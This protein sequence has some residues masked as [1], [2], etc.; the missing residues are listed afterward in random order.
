MF[1]N[2]QD[3]PLRFSHLIGDQ[4]IGGVER[5]DYMK[6]LETESYGNYPALELWPS[7]D[8]S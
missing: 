1:R 6:N 7:S 3:E 4:L 5:G 8:Q 2:E